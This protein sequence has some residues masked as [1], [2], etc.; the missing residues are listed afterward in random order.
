MKRVTNKERLQSIKED[1]IKGINF[2]KSDKIKIIK[3]YGSLGNKE[4]N[5]NVGSDLCYLYNAL[6]QINSLLDNKKIMRL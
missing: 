5:K 1:L 2:I 6:E 4:I 3:N